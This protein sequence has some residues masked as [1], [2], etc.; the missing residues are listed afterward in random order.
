MLSQVV[1]LTLC[2]LLVNA[3]TET[4]PNVKSRHVF[5]LAVKPPYA[6]E[7]TPGQTPV[8]PFFNLYGSTHIH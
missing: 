4:P 8:L 7:K 6:Y 5:D 2:S 3:L 1:V